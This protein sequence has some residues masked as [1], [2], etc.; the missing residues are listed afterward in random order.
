MAAV[1][2]AVAVVASVA[3]FL[4]VAVPWAAL[5]PGG[6]DPWEVIGPV[7]GVVAAGVLAA[8]GWWASQAGAPGVG[9]PERTVRQSAR[10]KGN[11]RQT[12][13]NDG[14]VGRT[15]RRPMRENIRQ[16][17]RGGGDVDQVGGDRA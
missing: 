6:N 8:L 7:G 10:A 14:V 13:G 2:W 15:G 11:V 9:G 5:S 1:R 12:A 16:K 17:G 3:A 4:A